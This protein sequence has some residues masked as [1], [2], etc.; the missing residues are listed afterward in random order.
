V[1]FVHEISVSSFSA[2]DRR[3]EGDIHLGSDE[4][5]P[6]IHEYIPANSNDFLL[7][8]TST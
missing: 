8:A 1:F 3:V 2:D 5:I 4:P 6:Y 7:V